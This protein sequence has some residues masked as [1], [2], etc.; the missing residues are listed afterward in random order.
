VD[1]FHRGGRRDGEHLHEVQRISDFPC[2]VED[3]V[4]PQRG[5]L[6]PE[7]TEDAVDGGGRDRSRRGGVSACCGDQQV[8][9][10]GVRSEPV[11]LV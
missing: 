11:P 6:K 2:F 3:P 1:V 4:L 10:D 5:W 7:P 8:R 9:V